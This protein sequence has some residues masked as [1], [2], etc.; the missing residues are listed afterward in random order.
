MIAANAMCA[1]APLDPQELETEV[2]AADEVLKLLILALVLSEIGN[3]N[4]NGKVD[5]LD[6]RYA[7]GHDIFRT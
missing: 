7:I 3:V 1:G 5:S 4:L 2:G 6:S